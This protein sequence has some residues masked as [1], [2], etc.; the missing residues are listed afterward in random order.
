MKTRFI[1]SIVKTARDE[2]IRMPWAR[3]KRRAEMIARSDRPA[4]APVLKRA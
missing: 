2:E 1:T 4:P 3:G